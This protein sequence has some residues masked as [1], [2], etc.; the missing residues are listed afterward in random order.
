MMWLKKHLPTSWSHSPQFGF[1]MTSRQRA[2][3]CLDLAVPRLEK[4]LKDEL[5]L[6][7]LPLDR[8]K[9]TTRPNNMARINHRSVCTT[10]CKW[11]YQSHL[12]GA[13]GG[14]AGWSKSFLESIDLTSMEAKAGDAIVKIGQRLG[15]LTARA[16]VGIE[17]ERLASHFSGRFGAGS[18][19]ECWS[20]LELPFKPSD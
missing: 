3:K 16:A 4:L 14:I 18:W 12:E 20:G 8:V 13:V 17:N 1:L 2:E 19:H 6:L 15:G 11:T 7:D 9:R 5:G 10:T